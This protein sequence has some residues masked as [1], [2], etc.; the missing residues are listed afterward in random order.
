MRLLFYSLLEMAGDGV[1]KGV[2]LKL[3]VQG[4][5]GSNNFG[6]RW[7]RGVGDLEN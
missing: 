6:L 3:D 4:Q 1:G 7:T 5:G 2:R